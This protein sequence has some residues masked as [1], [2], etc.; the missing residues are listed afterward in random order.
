MVYST[1]RGYGRKHPFVGKLRIGIVPVEMDSPQPGIGEIEV[2]GCEA[3][4]QSAG[5]GMEPPQFTRGTG[6]GFGQTVGE[7]L[8]LTPA[9][10]ERCRKTLGRDDARAAVQ[11]VGFVLSKPD[12]RPPNGFPG[13]GKL[14]QNTCVMSGPEPAHRLRLGASVAQ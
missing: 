1:P 12:S 14:P 4:H 8:F 5:P 11:E 7:A 2:T 10:R 9:D 3:L 13:Q 6:R